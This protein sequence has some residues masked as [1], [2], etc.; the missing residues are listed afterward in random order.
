MNSA[1]MPLEVGRQLAPSSSLCQTP[2]QET[3]KVAWHGLRGSRQMEWIAGASLPP[4][5]HFLRSGWFHNVS[6]RLQ[7][8]PPS[9]ERNSPPPIVPAQID[10]AVAPNSSA[11]ISS[12]LGAPSSSLLGK[13][14]QPVSL[15]VAPPSSD[16]C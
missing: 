13:A 7:V 16:I 15:H 2:P 10:P 8:S 14:G 1:Y 9:P 3:A 12:T 11:Q 6:T 4:P 5:N